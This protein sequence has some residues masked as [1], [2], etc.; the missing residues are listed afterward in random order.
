MKICYVGDG[1]SLHMKRWANYFARRGHEVHLCSNRFVGGYAKEIHLHSLAKFGQ[2]AQWPNESGVRESI[3]PIPARRLFGDPR[4]NALILV[5]ST[6]LMIPG[7]RSFIRNLDPDILHAHYA[8]DYGFLAAMTGFHPFVLTVWGSDM[9]ID[10]LKSK[11]HSHAVRRALAGADLITYDGPVMDMRIFSYMGDARKCHR[12]SHGVDT[13]QFR[14]GL[15]SESLRKELGIAGCPVVISTRKFSPIYDVETLVRAIPLVLRELPSA[16]FILAAVGE[17]EQFIRSLARTLGVSS[18]VR[19]VGW[20]P[21]GSLPSYLGLADV[22]VSTSLSDSGG[23]VSVLEAMACGLAAIITDILD[24]KEWVKDGENGY[25][26]PVKSPRILAE[27]ICLLLKNEK[28]RARM[29]ELSRRIVQQRAE[30]RTEMRK[31]E[32]LYEDLVIKVQCKNGESD[33][34]Q[35]V[36]CK[37]GVRSA[38]FVEKPA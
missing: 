12:I 13:A 5:L 31:M 21:H 1:V 32:K 15:A 2:S 18:S 36:E 25:L 22:F 7:F 3:L 9:L 16:K 34:M 17:E 35:K 10:T 14:P 37:F 23:S 6:A 8:T 24:N 30:H 27:R 4:V 19:F 20:I 28:T 38:R 11:I 29:G 26:I 33:S